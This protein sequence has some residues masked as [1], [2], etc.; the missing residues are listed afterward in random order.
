MAD[1]N[2]DVSRSCDAHRAQGTPL[3]GRIYQ[4]DLERNSVHA[5]YGGDARQRD[6]VD[7]RV[8]ASP[9]KS[10]DI[11]ARQFTPTQ[12]KGVNTSA[13]KLKPL[14]RAAIIASSNPNSP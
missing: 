10:S 11:G 13:R 5:G 14:R 12:A 7:L 8:P 6:V 4:R 2:A 9:G 3:H 1:T